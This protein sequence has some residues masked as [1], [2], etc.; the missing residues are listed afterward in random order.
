MLNSEKMLRPALRQSQR[1]SSNLYIKWDSNGTVSHYK[2]FGDTS[3]RT[4]SEG[5]AASSQNSQTVFPPISVN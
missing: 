1:L 2:S 3:Y 4:I 5:T